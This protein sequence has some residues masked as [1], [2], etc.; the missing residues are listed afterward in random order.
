[1]NLIYDFINCHAIFIREMQTI[2]RI[3]ALT[4]CRMQLRSS[5]VISGP[6]RIAENAQKNYFLSLNCEYCDGSCNDV[7][8]H[9]TSPLCLRVL[10]KG[11]CS[12]SK[13]ALAVAC[14]LRH[15]SAVNCCQIKDRPILNLRNISVKRDRTITNLCVLF[16]FESSNKSKIRN[17][18]SE[19]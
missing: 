7:H 1:M 11:S 14:G 18:R 9:A 12:P 4:D 2:E 17:C 8:K 13:S 5:H 3:L 19:V 10:T 6:I 16:T 15:R